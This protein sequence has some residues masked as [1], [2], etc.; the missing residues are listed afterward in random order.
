M[1]LFF[2]CFTIIGCIIYICRYYSGQVA[3]PHSSGRIYYVN[4][5]KSEVEKIR[6]VNLLHDLYLKSISLLEHLK[7]IDTPACKMLCSKYAYRHLQIE[8]LP[9]GM[10]NVF[11]FNVNKG[12]RISICLSKE[13][14]LNELFF[15]VLHE[16]AHGMT[17]AYS[18]DVQ[19]WD[20]FKFLIKVASQHNLYENKDYARKPIPFCSHTLN[21]NP[22]F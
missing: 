20:N 22:S 1:R 3:Y 2:A 10:M 4:N 17:V 15:V 9:R 21:H 13:N 19:F 12:D 11:A 6:K 18:H 8:E 7:K 5:T 16:L 14:G